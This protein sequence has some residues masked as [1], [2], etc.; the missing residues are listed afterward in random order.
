MSLL[1]RAAGSMPSSQAST[2]GA[3]S[4]CAGPG[5]ALCVGAGAGGGAGAAD[6]ASTNGEASVDTADT[7]ITMATHHGQLGRRRGGSAAWRTG[8]V[9]WSGGGDAVRRFTTTPGTGQ[10]CGRAARR[11]P[12]TAGGVRGLRSVAASRGRVAAVVGPADD[13]PGW[14]SS[15][16]RTP[17]GSAP[18]GDQARLVG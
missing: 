3:V 7:T 16:R 13:L 8:W 18:G 1:A 11:R 9:T 2:S 17:N 15:L 14:A 4:G 12:G 10:G 5:A 6:S